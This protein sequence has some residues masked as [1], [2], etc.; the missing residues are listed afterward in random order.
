[1][2]CRFVVALSYNTAFFGS[3]TDLPILVDN[4]DCQGNETSITKCAFET[5]TADC[6]HQEDAGVKC[7]TLDGLSITIY[8]TSFMQ[9]DLLYQ[10]LKNMSFSYLSTT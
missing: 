2:F 6:S 4:L 8:Y 7:Y 5:H 9:L 10:A 3:G 1:M